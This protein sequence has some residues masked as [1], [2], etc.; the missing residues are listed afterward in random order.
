ME[1][2]LASTNPSIPGPSDKL[3]M[4]PEILKYHE[5]LDPNHREVCDLLALEISNKNIVKRKGR[6]EMIV[7]RS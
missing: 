1:A 5:K 7:S 3:N 2:G 6:L 4:N